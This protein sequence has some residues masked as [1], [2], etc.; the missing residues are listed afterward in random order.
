MYNYICKQ[1]E[2]MSNKFEQLASEERIQKTAEALRKNGIEVFICE[3]KEQAKNKVLELIPEKSEVMTMVSA[4]LDALGIPEIINES[5]KY[6]SV[7]AK[8]TTMDPS[9]QM[10]EM[11]KLGAA[12][13]YAIGSVHAIT[14][15]GEILFASA[16]GSQL[17]A[18]AFSAGNVIWVAGTQKIVEDWD[19][20]IDRLYNHCFV[21]ENE[22][23]LKVYGMGSRIGKVLT[24]NAENPGRLNIILVKEN[25]GF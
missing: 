17:G 7:K 11:R 13:D 16:T 5:G 3:N 2:T 18:Y 19:D 12:P 1:E 6:D 21:K 8:L 4:T 23:A 14:E 25:L 15:T 22:R 9:T 20:G 10:N 24:I